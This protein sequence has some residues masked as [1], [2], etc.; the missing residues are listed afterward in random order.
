MMPL[1][2]AR[3]AL[4]NLGFKATAD[5][6]DRP[7][8]ATLLI[9]IRPRPTLRHFDPERIQ[10]WVSDEGRGRPRE[11]TYCTPTP[12]EA[13]FSWGLIRIVDR[14]GV[15]N[16][17]LAFGGWLSA[18]LVDG[19]L[20]AVFTSPAPILRRGGH[21]QGWDH[22]GEAAGAFFGRLTLAVDFVPGFEARLAAATPLER[23]AAFVAEAGARLGAA[24]HL[25]DQHADLWALLVAERRHLRL[26]APEAWA[27]GLRLLEAVQ[28]VHG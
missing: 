19:T 21:S 5:L 28:P 20:T 15:S 22:G 17:Y 25:R 4:E 23:F 1:P 16:E 2:M 27:G 26:D 14:L 13:T 3:A 9:A 8:P 18:G 24:A 6:P 11:I 12:I 7:G 10:Y